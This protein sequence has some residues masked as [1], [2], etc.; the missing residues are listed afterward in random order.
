[1]GWSDMK[2]WI[3]KGKYKELIEAGQYL[4]VAA[5]FG[6]VLLVIARLWTGHL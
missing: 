1:M 3:A 2:P 5:V 4:L 6:G